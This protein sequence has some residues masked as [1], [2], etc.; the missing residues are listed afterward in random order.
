MRWPRGERGPV[1]SAMNVELKLSDD[2]DAH[3]IQNLFPLYQHE[4][5]EFEELRANRHGV[6][7]AD[8]GVMTLAEHAGA[9]SPW[10]S[11]PE[12]LFPYLILVDGRPAGFNLIAAR[13]RL[14]DGIDADFVVHEF[15]VLH[16]YRRDGVAERAAVEA[17]G[18]HRGGWEIVTWPSHA[19]A[20]A[21]W[22]RVVSAY[23]PAAIVQDAPDHP[24]GERVSFVFDNSE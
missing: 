2:G 13:S 21:F 6:L 5:S 12:A 3:I 1:T 16:A 4:V 15:F 7:D 9:G 23:S 14:P 20:I 19:R 17:F 11:E 8:D 10:W 18:L 24:W 22:R